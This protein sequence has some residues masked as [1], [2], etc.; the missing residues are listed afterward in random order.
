M[1]GHNLGVSVIAEGIETEVQQKWLRALNCEY[2]Q[3]Y[4]FAKPMPGAAIAE[5]LTRALPV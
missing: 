1:M 3:G 5:L 2:G 4:L